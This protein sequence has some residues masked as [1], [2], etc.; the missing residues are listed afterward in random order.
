MHIS[1]EE[2]LR[3]YSRKDVQKAILNISKNREVSVKFGDKGFSKRPDI[4]LYEND[5]MDFVKQGA[6]S[7]H[8]SEERWSDPMLLKSGMSRKDLDELR[9][10]FDCIID[11]DS[12]F[13]EFSKIAT[14]LIIEALKFHNIKT[15]GLKFSGNRGFHICVPFESF[16]EMVNNIHTRLLFPEAPRYIAEYIK[17]IIR[18]YLASNILEKSSIEEIAASL[19][20]KPSDIVNNNNFNPFSIVE[21]DTVFISSRHMFR[22][23]FSL[24]EKSGLVSIPLKIN[25]LDDF[26]ISLAKLDR[27]KVE[28]DFIKQVNQQEATQL[29]IQALDFAKKIEKKEAIKND[30][31]YENVITR[32]PEE[33]FP[34]CIN[35]ILKGIPTDGR[36]RAIFILINFFKHMNYSIDEIENI[37]LEWN[38]RNYEPLKEGYIKAQISWHKRQNQKIL[39]PNCSNTMYY[40]GM[41][42]KC[43]DN[44]CNRYKN[45]VNCAI[46]KYKQSIL[47]LTKRSKRK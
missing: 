43:E 19:Q 3:Y 41:G 46:S 47:R 6:T 5:I 27:I 8:I 21:L 20:K 37:L 14:K 33:F 32:I 24:N 44:I 38:K 23:P 16:P 10:G 17:N 30:K 12:D 11:V 31:V 15:I 7:F 26:N 2:V 35:K 25:Q 36:K 1:N 22:A 34:D 4:L 39:P 28:E 13:V 42:C 29:I 18:D 9:L 45:P 40:A